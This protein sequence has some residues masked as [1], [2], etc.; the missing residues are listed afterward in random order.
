MRRC[1]ALALRGGSLSGAAV[2]LMALG[3]RLS[4]RPVTAPVLTLALVIRTLKVRV[5]M[6]GSY[7][8]MV[9]AHDGNEDDAHQDE[10]ECESRCHT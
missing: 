2:A 10:I 9:H 5:V 8:P 1:D 6:L 3:R 4:R 7:C